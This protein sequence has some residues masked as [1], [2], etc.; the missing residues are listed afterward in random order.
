MPRPKK[1]VAATV[2][3]AKITKVKKPAPK[4]ALTSKI[5][6][7]KKII[8]KPKAKPV[9]IDVIEDDDDNLDD[10]NFFSDESL[11]KPDFAPV[12]S[13]PEKN[14]ETEFFK[15]EDEA[16]DVQKKFFSDLV[17]EIKVKKATGLSAEPEIIQNKS[18]K[19]RISLYSRLALKFLLLVGVLAVLVFYFSFSKLTILVTPQVETIGD[20]L[21]LRVGNGNTA[22]STDDAREKI[23]GTVNEYSVDISKVYPA[24]GED[25][26]IGQEVTGKVTLVNNYVKDQPLV[27][28]TRLL[29]SDNKLFRL[30]SAVTI[31]AGGKIE[32]EVYADKASADMA[33]NSAHFTIP[34]LWAGLQ[35]KIYADSVE[36][37]SFQ[38]SSEKYVKASDLQLALR[39]VDSLVMAKAKEGQN[40]SADN[41][42][43]YQILDSVDA[44]TSAQAGDKVNE[45]TL[46]IKAKVAGVVFAKQDVEKLATAKLN[47]LI[48]DDKELSEFKPE[49]LSY[50]LENYDET[51]KTAAVKASFSGLMI[52]KNNADIIDREK[53]VNLNSSQIATYLSDYP[54]IGHYELK[55]FPTFIKK[56]PHLIDRI[57]VK[58]AK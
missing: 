39:D 14:N 36:P 52:L 25:A 57:E 53:L 18:P 11:A 20:T 10:S 48:P 13:V 58:I 30:K 29:S 3:K 32:A 47:L 16:M 40:F 50:T 34:G 49:S 56:A 4:T 8:A 24:T 6:P 21:F 35:D 43:L 7:A 15:A 1:T 38:S 31:P 45:F 46:T 28:T 33:I 19:K 37:F 42:V 27:A 44:K 5:A 51:E 12:A 23:N 41:I 9:I 2:S 54:E 22:S 17:S 55:F 26:L